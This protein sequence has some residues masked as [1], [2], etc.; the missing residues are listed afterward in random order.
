MSEQVRVGMV[1]TSWWADLMHLPSLKS[2]PQAQL[3][4]I[5]GRNADRAH[6]MAQKYDIPRV[7]TDHRAMIEQGNLDALIIA[8][9][10]D[11]H[12]SITMDALEAGLHVLCE[13]PLALNAGQARLMA[14]KAAAAGVKHM[15]FFTWRWLPHV[16]YLRQL[17]ADGYLGRCFHAQ[18]HFFGNYGDGQEYAWRF[19]PQRANGILGDLGSHMIDLARVLVGEIA[20]VNAQLNS[21]VTHYGPDGQPLAGTN[22]AALLTIEFANGAQGVLHVSAVAQMAERFMQQQIILHGEAGTLEINLPFEGPNQGATIR[23]ARRGEKAFRTF[24]IPT[25][26]WGNVDSTTPFATHL[27][28]LFAKQPVG[29]RL[30]IDSILEDRPVSPNF[31]DGFKVQQVLDAAIASHQT[32][33]RVQ[34]DAC[35]A[36]ID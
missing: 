1:G 6:E 34:I 31:Q 4:A 30:F 2:H 35:D 28:E 17:L 22:D 26:F 18:F 7:F 19:D 14:E 32:G 9:P 15:V 3:A 36:D 8:T 23:G 27:L 29:A 5:C 13:K 25:E 11:L 16:Q 33:R 24:P 10:D 12:Y 20:Q 21:Y